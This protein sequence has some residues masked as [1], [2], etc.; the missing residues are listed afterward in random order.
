MMIRRLL[1]PSLNLKHLHLREVQHSAAGKRYARAAVEAA[2]ERAGVSAVES[3]SKEIVLFQ[4]AYNE[5]AELREILDNPSIKNER[6]ADRI[7]HQNG[8][9][10]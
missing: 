8:C 9:R 10:P 7:A 1:R 2:L 6:E 5:S 3:L 4:L